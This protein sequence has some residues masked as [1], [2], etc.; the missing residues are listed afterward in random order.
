MTITMNMPR[1]GFEPATTTIILEKERIMGDLENFRLFARAKMNLAKLTASQYI[2]K[3]KPFLKG[4]S[5]VTD[6]DIQTYVQSKKGICSAGYVSN[7]ISAFKA[8]FREYKGLKVM[9]G[10]KHPTAPLKMKEE[11]EPKKVERFI[12]SIDNLRVKCIALLLASSGLRKGEVLSLNKEDVN[13]E[14]RCIIPKCHN[15]ET[16][17]SG[18]SFYNDEA[19]ACLIEYEKNSQTKKDKLF[20]IG[21]G[22]FLRAWNNARK[23]SGIYLKPKDLRDFFSQEMGKALI[24]DRYIDIFQGRSPR[25]IL[26]KHYTTQGIR[27]LR[28]IYDKA[29]LKI[30]E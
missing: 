19:E 12:S 16:K 5:V 22:T 18:I 9:D 17:H 7:V 26:S 1:A 30:L 6:K 21:D 3:L 2:C 15:G 20:A 27:L 11:I 23:K 4:K 28:E 10:Y 25:N 8:Y 14:N 24:P 29:N 13:R